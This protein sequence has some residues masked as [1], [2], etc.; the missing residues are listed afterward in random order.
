MLVSTSVIPSLPQEIIFEILSKL[1]VKSLLKFRCVSKSWLA[2][3]SIGN[4]TNFISVHQ[5]WQR[6]QQPYGLC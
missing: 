5:Q 2:L 3:I 6:I 4:F 1:P